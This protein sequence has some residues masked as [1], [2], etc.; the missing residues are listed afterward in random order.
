MYVDKD[1]GQLDRWDK[2]EEDVVGFVR[3][4]SEFQPDAQG[5]SG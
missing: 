3:K 1:S 5:C 2:N 4:D